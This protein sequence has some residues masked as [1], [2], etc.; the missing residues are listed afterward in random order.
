[1]IKSNLQTLL[2]TQSTGSERLESAV[3]K[4]LLDKI[5]FGTQAFGTQALGQRLPTE[6]E[7]SED[8]GVSR[9][10][11]RAALS[12]LRDFGLIVSRRRA[13]SFINS[14]AVTMQ[15]GY[16]P[17]GSIRDTSDFSRFRRL[18]EGEAAEL[19]ARNGVDARAA[20]HLREVAEKTQALVARGEES[21]GMD[22]RFHTTVELSDSSFLLETVELLRPHWILVGNFVRSLSKT[23]VRT[24]KRMTAEHRAMLDDVHGSESRVFQGTMTCRSK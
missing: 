14:G 10:V 18:I 12:K 13:G 8:N 11:V 4:T 16:S 2:E 5:R 23:R 17:L 7:L 21:V 1:M 3:F 9:P 22:I 24:G 15:T 20:K 19:A 6:H